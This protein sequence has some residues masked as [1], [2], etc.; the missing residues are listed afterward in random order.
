MPR[1]PMTSSLIAL[2]DGQRMTPPPAYPTATRTSDDFKRVLY[3]SE[4]LRKLGDQFLKF[5]LRPRA[6]D[7][8]THVS[9]R[10]EGEC[11]LCNVIPVGSLCDDE[12]V[13]VAR[14]EID[15]LDLDPHFP[16]Q[17]LGGL[18]PLGS[19]LNRTDPLVGPVKR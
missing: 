3:T 10:T 12:D 4:L 13:V 14:C 15:L 2:I 6:A 17:L 5:G 9:L 19:V 8:G 7:P 11:E 18:R 1:Y 16:R